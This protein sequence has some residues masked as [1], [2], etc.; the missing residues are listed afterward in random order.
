MKKK[1]KEK[2]TVELRFYDS[3]G[4]EWN[5]NT[6]VHA[7]LSEPIDKAIKKAA[8]ALEISANEVTVIT[9]QGT[10]VPLRKEGEVKNVREVVSNWGL[11][12]GLITKDVLGR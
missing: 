5:E 9:P 7:Y 1:E 2:E 11:S 10:S 4:G 8:T 6:T 3:R 12:F